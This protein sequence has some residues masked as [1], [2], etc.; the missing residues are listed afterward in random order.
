[1]Y[2][3]LDTRPCT[4]SPKLFHRFGSPA[5][6]GLCR[7]GLGIVAGVYLSR[8]GCDDVEMCGRFTNQF[9]WRELVELYR[10]TEPYL[11]PPSNL[12]PRFNFAPTDTGP[13]IRLDT[14]TAA[15]SRS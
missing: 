6:P 11:T 15:A 8:A 4:A 10:I 9:T 14:G 1:M 12:Q 7:D 5:R 3:L 2:P 13:V